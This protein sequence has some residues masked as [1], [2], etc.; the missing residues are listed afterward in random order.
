MNN[1]QS[2]IPQVVQQ[3]QHPPQPNQAPMMQGQHNNFA[4]QSQ[5][6]STAV[7]VQNVQPNQQTHTSTNQSTQQEIINKTRKLIN[8]L[9][10]SLAV[11]MRCVRLCACVCV[12]S[13]IYT[14]VCIT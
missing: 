6:Q 9:K 8:D 14:A 5:P 11:S 7:G 12:W 2:S 13:S 1:S 3:Q 10:V 4:N